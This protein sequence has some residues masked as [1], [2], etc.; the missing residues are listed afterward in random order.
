MLLDYFHPSRD[1]DLEH[2]LE[3]ALLVDGN[4][5]NRAL[6]EVQRLEGID[7]SIHFHVFLPA[8][9]VKLIAW[10]AGERLPRST[11]WRD[12]PSNPKDDRVPHAAAEGCPVMTRRACLA[13]ASAL[14]A[15]AA[16]AVPA[17]A[18]APLA[19]RAWPQFRVQRAPSPA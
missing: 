16:A 6:S 18:Q 5:G 2:F 19:G 7:Y 1:R 13:A 4:Q 8:D 11:S 3:C 14:L 15:V 17:S 12:P 10:F 9:V